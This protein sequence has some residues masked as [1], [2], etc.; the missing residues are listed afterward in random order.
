[1]QQEIRP[2]LAVDIIEQLHRQFAL[3]SGGRG[4][5]GS[6]IITFP[7]FSGFNEVSDEDF[8]NVVTYLTSIPRTSSCLFDFCLMVLVSLSNLSVS[9]LHPLAWMLLALASSSS[10]TAGRTNGTQQSLH[11]QATIL[12]QALVEVL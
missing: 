10:W 1:M 4:K 12:I 2:L 3:L 11:S 7:E 6:P 5:D 9:V 8:V